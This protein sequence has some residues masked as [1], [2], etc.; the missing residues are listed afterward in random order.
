MSEKE[1]V[2]RYGHWVWKG[3]EPQQETKKKQVVEENDN[4]L[5]ESRVKLQMILDNAH[6][7]KKLKS[8]ESAND[9]K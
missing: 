8:K 4:N 3:Y 9:D 2:T 7:S 1:A 5:K 6:K